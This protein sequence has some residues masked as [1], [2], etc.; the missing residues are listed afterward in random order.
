MAKLDGIAL[1]LVGA[2]ALFTY[3]GLSGKSIPGAL[4]ALIQGKSPAAAPQTQ[5][6]T[7]TS[8]VPD[9][10]IGGGS[11]TGQQIAT[12]ALAYQGH[13]YDFGGSPGLNGEGPW[14][15]S[16]FANWVIGHDLGLAIPGV[17]AGSYDGSTHGPPTGAW[18]L[19]TG[20]TRVPLAQMQAGDIPCWQTHMGIAT[21]P[22][23]M[24]SAEDPANGTRVA[25]GN[26]SGFIPGEV[27][28]VL[29]LKATLAPSS[30]SGGK[31]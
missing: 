8:S 26:L 28:F 25:T 4:Q 3:A 18:L 1:G 15:C 2:G 9:V 22:D 29:R 24:I 19:W 23:S 13:A 10:P 12:D 5:P 14:D 20:V 21:G 11:A 30:G 16:S 7:G 31:R 27:L 17:P 6:I